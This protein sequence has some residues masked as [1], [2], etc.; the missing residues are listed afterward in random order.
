MEVDT[1]F[2][3]RG[4]DLV[5]FSNISIGW[6]VGSLLA[7]LVVLSFFTFF[8]VWNSQEIFQQDSRRMEVASRQMTI[9]Q[10]ISVLAEQV[11][12][13]VNGA[14]DL[15]SESVT[16]YDESFKCLLNGGIVPGKNDWDLE[17]INLEDLDGLDN[18]ISSLWEN[19]RSN[20]LII[21]NSPLLINREVVT[22]YG[23]EKVLGKNPDVREAV[24]ELRST[25]LELN[26]LDESLV[27]YFSGL[28]EKHQLQARSTIALLFGISVLV[29]F[30]IFWVAQ[31]TISNPVKKISVVMDEIARGQLEHVLRYDGKDEIGLLSKSIK[32]LIESLTRASNFAVQ[33]GVGNLEIDHKIAGEND[34]LGI[35]LL[36]MKSQLQGIIKETNEVVKEASENG[37]L[38]SRL[39]LEDKTGIWKE[40]TSSVNNLLESII[41]PLEEV[42]RI[43]ASMA[44]GDLRIR[45]EGN[46]KGDL[47]RLTDNL[48]LALEGLNELLSSVAKNVENV[49]LSSHEMLAGSEEMN[50]NTGE[51]AS[52]ISQMSSGAQNQVLKVDESSGLLEDVLDFSKKIGE[53]GTNI[54]NVA[55]GGFDN[56][57]DGIDRI[58]KVVQDM[59]EISEYSRVASESIG[60]LTSRSAEIT[61]ILGIITDVARQTNLLALNAAIE[62]AQAGEAGRGF[63][64]VAEEIR[65]L[66]EDSRNSAKEIEK[67]VT[68]VQSDTNNAA[69]V[70]QQMSKN[71]KSGEESSLAASM[72][73]KKISDSYKNTLEL[74]QDIRD[75]SKTQ[76]SNINNVVSITEGIV[77]IAEQTASGT[78][79][80]ASSSS[81]LAKGMENYMQKS[82][83]LAKIASDLQERIN[84]FQLVSDPVIKILRQEDDD[85]L[86]VI[87]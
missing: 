40:M 51:I 38:K 4:L 39:S 14:R 37:N 19:Y 50:L 36:K 66:A 43:T 55:Q 87:S 85:K 62:A 45:Y 34:R 57:K 17:P 29:A 83:L 26:E 59:N 24:T 27:N 80:V 2:K 33:I 46:E 68:D 20:A 13:D 86:G 18:S 6:K 9:S 3:L 47:K 11:L 69:E 8:I 81:E 72:E 42:N 77:V 25:T 12:S 71:V 82:T 48:N 70:I 41:N 23:V 32:I 61:R 53:K 16:L 67:L 1:D 5:R 63:A 21:A 56:S 79:E 58:N 10:K 73:F 60:I 30:L 74:A 31:R 75:S 7:A 76:I 28:S 64:V 22:V 78:E 44:S 52:A 49:D 54:S 84:K 15:L 65:K 35:A